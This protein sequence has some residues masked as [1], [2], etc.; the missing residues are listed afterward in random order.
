MAEI[1][2]VLNF[3]PLTYVYE[4]LDPGFTLTPGHFLATNRKL[5]LCNSSDADYHY[6][7]D[8]QLNQDSVTKLIKMWKRGQKQLYLFWKM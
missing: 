8:Y 3:R 7:E 4:D 2:A 5:G 1:Q 6:D